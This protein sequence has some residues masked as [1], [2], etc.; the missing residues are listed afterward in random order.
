MKLVETGLVLA[1]A[2]LLILT[3]C[4]RQGPGTTRMET[5]MTAPEQPTQKVQ[6]TDAEWRE[7]LTP[8]QYRILREAGTDRPFGE[9]YDQFQNQGTGSYHCAGCDARLFTSNE[10]F[11]SHCGWP[12][13]YDPAEASNVKTLKD[14]SGGMVRTEVICAVCDGHLGHVFEGEGFDTPTD[15]R[16]CING[17]SLKFVPAKDGDGTPDSPAEKTAQ[18]PNA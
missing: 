6:K 10:K 12:S 8:E 18:D 14:F 4:T 5:S 9:I 1:A 15:Q 17:T 2:A 16:Y 7:A 11:D 13:F 3:G